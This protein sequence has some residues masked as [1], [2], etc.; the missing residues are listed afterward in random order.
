MVDFAVSSAKFTNTGGGL[1][2][3]SK[4]DTYVEVFV[5]GVSAKKT[6]LHKKSNHPAWNETFVMCVI[7]AHPTF[8][9]NVCVTDR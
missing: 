9:P 4:P 7:C 8:T 6:G 3:S 5:D 1:L 2:N